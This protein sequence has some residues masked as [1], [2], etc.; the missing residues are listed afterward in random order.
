MDILE[1]TSTIFEI[2]IYHID[3]TVISEMAEERVRKLEDRSVM[4]KDERFRK[5][6]ESQASVGQ[7]KR[8]NI[9]IIGMPEEWEKEMGH[10][11]GGEIMY[12]YTFLNFSKF[13]GKYEF[14]N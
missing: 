12:L 4:Q 10:D 8:S 9:C 6:T 7:Y 13:V 5:W 14:K 1:L 11:F 2:K 3:L